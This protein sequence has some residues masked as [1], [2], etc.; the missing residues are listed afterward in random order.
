M[1][2]KE[3]TNK[4]NAK[5]VLSQQE[6]QF[7]VDGY[8]NGKILEE[9]AV[10]FV[11][12]IYNNGLNIEETSNLT[13]SMAK[14]GDM[15]DLSDVGECV[16][17]HSTGGVSDTTT[18][19]I[20]PI[21]AS[22]GIKVAK[23]SGRSLG[24]TGGTADKVEVF[25]GYDNYIPEQEFKNNIKEIGACLISQSDKVAVADKKIYALRDRT[26]LV[27][28]IA[29][30]ASSI[31]SKKIACGAKILLLDVKYGNGAFM[32]N[33]ED[34]KKLATVMCNI[35]NNVGIKTC[36][37]ISNM[38][39]PLSNYVG[40]NLEVF[41]AIETLKG[42]PSN[43]LTLSKTIVGTILKICGKAESVKVGMEM[44]QKAI[45]SGDALNKL[46]QIV[47]KQ[48]GSDYKIDHKDVLLNHNQEFNIIASTSGVLSKINCK[49]LGNAVHKLC[50]LEADK[51]SKNMC[52]VIIKKDKNQK[53]N[54][55]DV[56]ATVNY[57]KAQNVSEIMREI[58]ECF[59]VS[60]EQGETFELVK[61]I[62]F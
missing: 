25:D 5:Q 6:I 9:E 1:D 39:E 28:N 26:G 33:F 43:L 45:E 21:L 47:T 52:G 50:A 18:L 57:S 29:L 4:K 23:M 60:L 17:K 48:H 24:W 55:G 37:V 31:M 61:E 32:E 56:I 2:I 16:D 7:F 8:V 20:V 27:D 34:A 38:N 53:V 44:A 11:R 30:I 42:K 51:E 40:N 59:V 46:K 15:V 22:L 62:V 12:A 41:S 19:V 58:E 49:K 10:E 14:S 36:A 54:K 35:G 3:L 13:M